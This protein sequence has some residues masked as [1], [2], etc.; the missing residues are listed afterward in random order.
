[1]LFINFH[2]VLSVLSSPNDSSCI[3]PMDLELDLSR[4]S[5]LSAKE[6]RKKMPPNSTNIAR[7]ILKLCVRYKHSNTVIGIDL[8]TTN[9]AVAAVVNGKPQILE[10]DEGARTTPSVVAYTKDQGVL[11]GAPA[12][13]QAVVNLQNTFFATKRLIGR[14]YSDE[15]VKRDIANVKYTIV[16][17]TNSNE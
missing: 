14:K 4:F 2:V 8:G 5:I 1:M 3:Y 13:R 10:N 7:S 17:H 6:P 9:S 12:K 15:E 11:V 16:Q